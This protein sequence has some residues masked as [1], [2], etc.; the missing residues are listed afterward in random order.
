MT[1]CLQETV[2]RTK[3]HQEAESWSMLFCCQVLSSF[4]Y[5]NSPRCQGIHHEAPQSRSSRTQIPS[6]R[7]K[8]VTVMPRINADRRARLRP[9]SGVNSA[10]ALGFATLQREKH[11]MDMR[12]G[13]SSPEF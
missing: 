8:H 5:E 13:F 12:L 9:A 3:V 2:E 6:G 1:A 4:A 11:E 10:V 7:E